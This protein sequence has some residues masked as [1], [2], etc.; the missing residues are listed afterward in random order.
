MGGTYAPNIFAYVT[1]RIAARGV[2]G[3]LVGCVRCGGCGVGGGCGG[4]LVVVVVVVRAV[5]KA[6]PRRRGA[7]PH[8]RGHYHFDLER[9]RV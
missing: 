3:W 4:G 8:S 9:R 2:G 6:T 1:P 7:P 5:V